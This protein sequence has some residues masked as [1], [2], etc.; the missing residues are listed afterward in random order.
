[1][2]VAVLADIHANAP[3]LRAVLAQLDSEQPDALVVAGDVVGGP[4]VS[5]SLDL[6]SVR[7]EA[8]HWLRGNS[9]REAVAVYN[10]S[11]A[12]DDAA[13]RAASWSARALDSRWRDRLASWP[14]TFPLDGVRFCHRSP[15][16]DDEILTTAT[17]DDVLADALAGVTES[18][19]VGGHTHRQFIRDLGGGLTYAN[20]GSVGLPYEGRPGAF[21]MMVIDGVPELH[22]TTYDVDAAARELQ[23]SGLA[24]DDQLQ[25]SLLQPV[26]PDQVAAFLERAAGR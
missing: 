1:M 18:L 3:A 14:I 7:P 25:R 11:P 12:S 4:L 20:A 2:R 6:L 24:F 5:E 13:G 15:L 16:R 17:P 8:V 23:A 22:E 19:V 10:G 21:W 9:E 26:D